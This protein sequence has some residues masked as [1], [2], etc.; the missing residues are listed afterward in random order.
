[1]V[2]EGTVPGL[3]LGSNIKT[4]YVDLNDDNSAANNT[5]HAE[6]VIYVNAGIGGFV[7]DFVI[8]DRA[9]TRS[10][11]SSSDRDIVM[12]GLDPAT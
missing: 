7:R 10:P 9:A 3:P 8:A 5:T 12:A 6:V 1:M 11:T 4:I 2:N